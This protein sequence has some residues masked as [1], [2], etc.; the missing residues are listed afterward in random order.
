MKPTTPLIGAAVA[1]SC[2]AG[3]SLSPEEA[4]RIAAERASAAGTGRVEATI[5]GLETFEG[6]LGAALFLASDGFPGGW[7]L[8]FASEHLPATAGATFVFEGVPA[9]EIALSV[10]HDLDDDRML[11]T[12]ALGIPSEPWGVS[13]G[14]RGFFGPPEYEDAKLA[15]EPGQTLAVEVEVEQ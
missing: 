11:D 7:E 2:A 4:E 6:A 10:Y 5:V 8:A 14:A 15:L 3:S 9:G 12:G 1:A 13:R